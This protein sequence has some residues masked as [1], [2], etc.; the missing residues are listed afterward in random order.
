VWFHV[1]TDGNN[2][3]YWSVTDGKLTQMLN[4]A[5]GLLAQAG[6][7]LVQAGVNYFRA[8]QEDVTA[9]GGAF[10]TFTERQ[11]QIMS[12]QR[13]VAIE[14]AHACV[15]DSGPLFLGLVSYYWSCCRSTCR[16]RQLVY[17]NIQ[18]AYMAMQAD[19]MDYIGCVC[20]R[21]LV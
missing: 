20:P 9:K 17:G 18:R 16:C 21:Y 7:K 8:S 14:E 12:D 4:E 6:F 3:P 15:A 5:N 2:K 13:Y 10:H 11:V 19:T 1:P